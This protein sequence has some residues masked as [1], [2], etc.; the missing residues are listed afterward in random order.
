MST[1]KTMVASVRKTDKL[2]P[3]SQQMVNLRVKIEQDH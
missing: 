1:D 2:S 3:P